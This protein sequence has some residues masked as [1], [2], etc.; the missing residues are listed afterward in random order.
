[1]LFKNI[2]KNLSKKFFEKL[3]RIYSGNYKNKNIILWFLT[4]KL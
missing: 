1:M 4:F 3:Y 2:D